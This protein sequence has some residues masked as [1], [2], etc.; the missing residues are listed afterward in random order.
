MVIFAK[1]LNQSLSRAIALAEEQ[2]YG[3][4]TPE[5]VLL[6]L[7]DDPD[8]IPVM[9]ACNVDL[10]KLRDAVE[11]SMPHSDY[12]PASDED[13]TPDSDEDDTWESD[14][15]PIPVEHFQVD[16]QR[17]IAHARSSEC[18]DVN[19]ADVLVAMLEGSV[20]DL[21]NEHGITRYDV[22]TFI[23]HGITK[24]ARAT[25]RSGE[26]VSRSA[27]EAPS[28]DTTGTTMFRVCLLNDN[29]TP[30]DFVVHVLEQVFELE[31]EH[32]EQMMLRLHHDGVVACGTFTREEA[33]ARAVRVMDLARQ[34]Q[35]PLR[36]RVQE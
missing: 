30:M 2:S 20:G 3:C 5:H 27:A 6:A 4:A 34:H 25:S 23:S 33:E 36:C 31:N 8:A 16:L 7:I 19:S 32:A 24:G 29:Y 10:E 17:A 1:N 26:I 22:T 11:A 12:V 14:H 28:G 15:E 13:D 18:E 21:M 35:H 9:R